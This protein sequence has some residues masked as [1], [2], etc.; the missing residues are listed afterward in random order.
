MP[1]QTA[2]NVLEKD[3]LTTPAL[4]EVASNL[5][6]AQLHLRKQPKGYAGL[7][8]ARKSFNEMILE[9]MSK[10]DDKGIEMQEPQSYQ[11]IKVENIKPQVDRFVR[12]FRWT[13]DGVACV[14]VVRC[15]H[16]S[17]VCDLVRSFRWA[18]DGAAFVCVCGAV[19][20]YLG[21]L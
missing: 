12:S 3:Y 18:F 21:R 16:T 5:R 1:P 2:W 13:F 11:G 17:V 19:C 4:V 9:S 20:A 7:D 8:G 15:A 14:C 10:Y 6:G